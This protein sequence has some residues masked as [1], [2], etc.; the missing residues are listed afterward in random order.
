LLAHEL[1][2]TVQQTGAAA[3]KLMRWVAPPDWLDY[4]GLTVDAIERAYIELAYEPG[5]EKD[6]QRFVNTVFLTIDL[7][8]AAAP[9]AGGGGLA[10][11]ASRELAAVG[12]NTVPAS[13]KV[14]IVNQVAKQMGWTTAK[15]A[16]MIQ[17]LFSAMAKNDGDFDPQK[18][19][20][21]R[22]NQRQNPQFKAAVREAERK[23]GFRLEK[24]QLDMLHHEITKQNMSY[25]EIVEHAV[26]MFRR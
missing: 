22:S 3:P 10:F 25:H 5:Q 14:R 11:R 13:A 23:L 12:W 16:Q 26:S 24:E 21:P 19:G 7:I 17:R 2:H 8:L 6:F 4:I 18:K 1:A 15:T 20:T 9:G